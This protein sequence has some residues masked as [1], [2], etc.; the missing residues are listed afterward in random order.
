MTLWGRKWMQI[1]F[2][3]SWAWWQQHGMGIFVTLTY[4]HIC[5]H[6]Y[7]L[8]HT[9]VRDSVKDLSLWKSV[10]IL[11]CAL[12]SFKLR[13]QIIIYCWAF[14]LQSRRKLVPQIL[15]FLRFSS[16]FTPT[17]AMIT[18]VVY[19]KAKCSQ[20]LLIGHLSWSFKNTLIPTL[21]S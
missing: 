21:L 7:T 8:L 18:Q 5:I 15:S 3:I 9:G 20:S 19:L 1:C 4:I 11:C 14:Q 6:M 13:E 12:C 2:F 17:A 16:F 10:R